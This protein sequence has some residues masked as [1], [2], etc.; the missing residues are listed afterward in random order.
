MLSLTLEQIA[1]HLAGAAATDRGLTPAEAGTL[2][3]SLDDAAR[4]ARAFEDSVVPPAARAD[5]AAGMEP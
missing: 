2:A 4:D 1:A 3:A 5:T